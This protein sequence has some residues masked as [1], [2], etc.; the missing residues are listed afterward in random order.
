MKAAHDTRWNI[1]DRDY[2][3][4]HWICPVCGEPY[5]ILDEAQD[6]LWS[7][8]PATTADKASS[9]PSKR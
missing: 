9:S 7:H 4:C 3:N 2:S 1:D 6:C 8:I 5:L